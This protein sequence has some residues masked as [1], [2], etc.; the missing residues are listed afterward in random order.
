MD[1]LLLREFNVTAS[2]IR[3]DIQRRMQEHEQLLRSGVSLFNAFNK[4]HR[5]EWRIFAESLA[6]EQKLPGIQGIGFSLL[7]PPSQLEAHIAEFRENFP[8]YS[9]KPAGERDIYSAIIFLEPF[10]WRNQR[11]FGYDMMSEPVRRAAMERARDSNAAVLTNKVHLV[12]E[13]DEDVQA[14]VLLYLPVYRKNLPITSLTQRQAALL[15]WVYS[16]YRMHDMMR[17]IL[18]QSHR[19]DDKEARLELYDGESTLVDHL[20]YDSDAKKGSSKGEALPHLRQQTLTFDVGNIRWTQRYSEAD[21]PLSANAYHHLWVTLISGVLITLALFALVLSLTGTQRKAEAIAVGLTKELSQSEFRY[22]TVANFTANWEFW[23]LADGTVQYMSPSC[24]KHTG[25]TPNEFYAD[26]KLLQQIIHADDLPLYTNH[27]HDSNDSDIKPLE[28]RILCKDG[29]IR[30]I[31]HLCRAVVAPNG[32]PLGRRGSN[33][34][35]TN[36]KEVLYR[37]QQKEELLRLIVA[38]TGVGIW[39]WHLQSGETTFNERWAEIIGYTLDELSP[40]SIETWLKYAHPDDLA[41]SEKRLEQHWRGESKRYVFESRM[42]HKAGHWVWVFDTGRV[43][44]WSSDGKPLRMVGTHLDISERKQIELALQKSEQLFK[45]M[46]DTSP[47]A[48]YLSSGIEQRGDYLNPTFIK[49]FGY[50]LEEVPSIAEWWSKAYPDSEYRNTIAEEWQRRLQHAI[51]TTSAI[52][53]MQTVVTC[54]D[55]SKK[56]ISWGSF[57]S[58]DKNWAFGLD[59]T[60]I[61]QAKD[62][63]QLA[64]IV[65]SN[66]LNG[67]LIT[68]ANARIVDCNGA[69]MRISGYAR[70]EILDHT[71]KLFS[72]GRQPSTFYAQMWQSLNAEGSWH[73]EIWNR[74]KNGEVYVTLAS[75]TAIRN[76]N[77]QLTHYLGVY[78]DINFI[79]E[80]E[81]ELDRIAHYDPLTGIPNRRLFIDRLHQAVHHVKR[82]GKLLAICFL[83]LDGFKPVNDR[84]GHAAGDSVLIEI[85]KRLQHIMREVD[86]I[87]RFGGDEFVLLLTDLSTTDECRLFLSRVLEAVALPI[88]LGEAKVQVS[89]SIGATLYPIDDVNVDS[90][91]VHADQAMYQAKNLG[92]NRYHFHLTDGDDA[93]TES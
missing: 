50:T 73:G 41:A 11:A 35:I 80:R 46:S 28:F 16:P 9:V 47:L 37:L 86:T 62:K 57:S 64:A 61:E 18:D 27:L 63:L 49:L 58:G 76:Q 40:V 60:E 56:N 66:S 71:P 33:R 88:Q 38:N 5:N 3:Q 22:R 68:D 25:Y 59:Y 26:P 21:L 83:D 75:I 93:E 89:V 84:Y 69:F 87:S 15:G 44:E 31:S 90:L 53:P 67:V 78:S 1:N 85:T 70:Y 19:I 42:R 20:L 51:A 55:G 82:S 8:D 77:G 45:A 24:E 32:E 10:D 92:K 43:V 48:I 34:D 4:V 36:E 2:N 14:G 65:F 39:D 74:H 54:K 29:E 91:L 6:F 30:W 23:T 7:I 79:K 72:S 17:G 12:Q 13:T 81:S 52:E